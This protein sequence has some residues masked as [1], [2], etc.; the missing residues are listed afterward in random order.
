MYLYVGRKDAVLLLQW[1][2]PLQKFMIVRVSIL[3]KYFIR[4]VFITLQILITLCLFLQDF[5]VKLP[6]SLT[7]FEPVVM[8]GSEYPVL[9]VGAYQLYELFFFTCLKLKSFKLDFCS[10]K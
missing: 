8:K 3:F 4:I 10:S 7:I 6:P 5:E 9:C 1:Y 2:E